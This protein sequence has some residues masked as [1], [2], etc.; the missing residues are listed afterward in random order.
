MY[1]P[2]LIFV[3]WKMFNFVL[4]FFVV[5]NKKNQHMSVKVYYKSTTW[6]LS[7]QFTQ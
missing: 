2:N 1:G 6:L 4:L 7:D 3:N 5:H